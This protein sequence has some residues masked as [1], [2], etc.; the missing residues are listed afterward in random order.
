MLQQTQVT[1]VIPYY[2]KFLRRFPTVTALARARQDSVLAMWSGLGYYARARNLH[3]AAKIIHADGFPATVEDWC[4][5]P[6]VGKS[7]AAA[8]VVF[9]QGSR[10]AILDGNVK[11]V[12]ARV[13]ALPL[14]PGAAAD[15]V[16]WDSA[17][18]L[19]PPKRNIRP[20][21]QGLMDLGATVCL[22]RTPH[23]DSCPL[24]SFCRAHR[25]GETHRY[26]LKKPKKNKPVKRVNM[27]LVVC[28]G[29]VLL[30]HRPASGIWGGLWS[31]PESDVTTTEVSDTGGAVFR[32][33]WSAALG[34]R[35]RAGVQPTL[36]FEHE[37][38]HYHLC[39]T[40]LLCV[41]ALPPPSLPPNCR[42]V[43]RR[44]WEKKGLPAPVRVVL[45]KI[46]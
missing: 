3:K 25:R 21:T 19:L 2:Q 14:S 44:E 22:R 34:R 24:S 26:P 43:G 7:T 15:A 40:V 1:A 31:L 20:Y 37:F 11:R 8:V 29:R 28:D 4:A 27:L 41:V 10:H 46:G 30:Q 9:S 42:W 6:G 16:L 5:L 39:A 12:L 33:Q 32:R 36:S 35:L 18:A 45:E 23:C 38:T 17:A 13:L